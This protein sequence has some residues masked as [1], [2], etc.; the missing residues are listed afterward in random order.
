LIEDALSHWAVKKMFGQTNV[1]LLLDIIENNSHLKNI[2]QDWLTDIHQ[3]YQ[4]LPF[5]E[6][7]DYIFKNTKKKKEAGLVFIDNEA[8]EYL[9]NEFIRI[10]DP[11]KDYNGII[12][13]DNALSGSW[14]YHLQKHFKDAKIICVETH[15]YYIEHLRSMGFSVILNKDLENKEYMKKIKYWLLNPPYQKDAEGQNDESNKQGSFWFEFVKEVL[16]SSASAEDAKA[17]VVSPKS[18]FGA[19]GFGRSTYKVNQ[20]REN[21]EFVHIWPDLSNCFPGIG[22]EICGYAIDKEKENTKVTVDGFDETITVDGAVPTPFHV[23]ITAANVLKNCWSKPNINFLE[24]TNATDTDV[25]LKVN[26]GRYKLW[27]KTFVGLNKDTEHNQQGAIL[28]STEILGYQSAIKSKLWEYIFKILGG[29][30]GNS[31]TGLMKYMPIMPDMT[32]AYTDEEWFK[33]FNI[34]EKMQKDIDQYLKEYK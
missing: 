17:L 10:I 9:T 14:P 26:G 4:S 34:D 13:V 25:V 19:G 20:I 18:I 3:A 6:L 11:P 7:H 32:K 12:A 21:A 29:E 24:H 27:K 2:M 22:I 31:V 1:D 8:A 5:E 28:D 15:E 23:S 16:T 30:K 33:A